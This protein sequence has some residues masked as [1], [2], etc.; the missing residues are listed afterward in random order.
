MSFGAN[1]GKSVKKK[2]GNRLEK[3]LKISVRKSDFLLLIK[4]LKKEGKAWRIY[5]K[6][7]HTVETESI[8]RC[9]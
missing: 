8:D 1:S 7:P 5:R 3:V 6:I 4:L 9:G 2:C